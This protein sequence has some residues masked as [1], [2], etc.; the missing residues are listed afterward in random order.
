MKLLIYVIM[1]EA[2]LHNHFGQNKKGF[3][4]LLVGRRIICKRMRYIHIRK[5]MIMMEYR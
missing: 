1:L 2:L 5:N 4:N 3:E